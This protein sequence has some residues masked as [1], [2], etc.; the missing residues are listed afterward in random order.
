MRRANKFYLGK[1]LAGVA[2]AVAYVLAATL[3]RK[4][5]F[6]QE[7]ERVLLPQSGVALA[8][9][10]ILGLRFWPVVFVSS[11]LVSIT[12]GRPWE[13]AELL[14]SGGKFD[15]GRPWPF[16][17]LLATGN[18]LAAAVGTWLIRRGGYRTGMLRVQDVYIFLLYGCGLAP[19][20][21]AL[22]A[23]AGILTQ[24][25]EPVAEPFIRSV[26]WKRWFGHAV[27]NL[28]VAPVL[29]TWS[30]RPELK[31]PPARLVETFLL[32]LCLAMVLL[33]VFSRELG[34]AQLDYPLSF[35]PFPVIIWAAL[36]YG[37]RGGA[38]ATFLLAAVA[39]YGTSGGFG[40]FAREE[41]AEGLVLLQV[42]LV[43]IALS[44]LFLGSAMAERRQMVL[45]LQLHEEELTALSARLLQAR[46]E[47]RKVISR[48]IHDELG[49][50]LTGIKMGIHALSRK[51]DDEAL[52]DSSQR[53]IQQT[54][55]AVRTVRDIATNLR[56]GI[57]DDL[58]IVAALQWLVNDFEARTGM[59]AIMR[60]NVDELTLTPDEK[61]ALF[62][63]AQEALTNISRHAQALTVQLDLTKEDGSVTLSVMDD[64][65]GVDAAALEGRSLG[66]VG[67]R[68]RIMLLGGTFAIGPG[69][70]V[71]DVDGERGGGT[72]IVVSVPLKE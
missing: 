28:I 30:R 6:I 63:V 40:P 68:E 27:S 18:T 69:E 15:S 26:V 5:D 60:T 57:L 44:A 42:Y 41:R 50:Q 37:P 24:V 51:L 35:L 13:Y 43:A 8:G 49:Q 54:D 22:F 64:G 39:M 17:L 34:M 47:E 65:V 32:V 10:I 58:G 36:R 12:A 62:R 29:L 3:G 46:E 16:A 25:S 21:N 59:E 70:E 7:N 11:L 19:A 67:M 53:L 56:P 23:I 9:L 66:V 33:T 48:E 20:I 1:A 55:D 14:M 4:L 52:L 72:R 38:T 31:Y 2:L 71:D 45:D 61:I